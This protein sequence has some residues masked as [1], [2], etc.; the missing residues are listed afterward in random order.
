M[1]QADSVHSTPPTNSPKIARDRAPSPGRRAFLSNVAALSVA[2]TIT[3][4]AVALSHDPIFAA[5]DAHKAASADISAEVSEHSRLESLL[6][7]EKRKSSVNAFE[8]TIVPTDDPRWIETERTVM[9]SFEAETDAACVL[10]SVRPTT[11]AGV[12]A[13]LQY[14]NAADT[15]GETWPRDLQ[16]D[17]GKKVR[18]WHY[19]LIE[20]LA[21]VLPGMV[22]A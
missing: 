4:P 22:S 13:L 7:R 15:D 5:I 2:A 8:E 6:P 9:R 11:I 3:G 1:D 18:S 10:V 17:D 21:E 19:F 16:S 20:S 12:L 14:V